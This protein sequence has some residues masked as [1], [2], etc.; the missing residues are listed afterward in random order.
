MSTVLNKVSN[1]VVHQLRHTALMKADLPTDIAAEIDLSGLDELDNIM[2]EMQAVALDAATTVAVQAGKG[3]QLFNQLNT[4]AIAAAR[5]RAGDMVTQITDSTRDDLRVIIS[6]GLDSQLTK[7]DIADLI[8][9]TDPAVFSEDR[10]QLIASTEMRI[11]NGDGALAG[12][13]EVAALGVDVKKEWLPDED[14]C[15]ECQAN[16]DQGPIDL[17]AEFE[18]GDDTTPA[19]PRCE[20]TL[21]SF[22]NQQG[23]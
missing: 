2:P 9:S 12:M 3:T 13:E 10:A 22:I 8:Q 7:D 17:D 23:E 4:R 21:I 15:P 19:H 1:S 11:A 14:P 18:S 6:S 16:A 20:C 5:A